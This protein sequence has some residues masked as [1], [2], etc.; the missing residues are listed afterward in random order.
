MHT[1]RFDDLTRALATNVSRR[2]VLKILGGSLVAGLLEPMH[3]WRRP[4]VAAADPVEFVESGQH[5]LFG[6]PA[7]PE[8]YAVVGVHAAKKRLL[9]RRFNLGTSDVFVDYS[10]QR[11]G[12]HACPDGTY[13]R[14][15]NDDHNLLIC[16][17]PVERGFTT[18]SGAEVLSPPNGH[19][20]APQRAGMHVCSNT[21]LNQVVVGIHAS[22]N[23]FL[24]RSLPAQQPPVPH[25]VRVPQSFNPTRAR[26]LLA[27]MAAGMS[28][29]DWQSLTRNW[30]THILNVPL[31]G[32]PGDPRCVNLSPALGTLNRRFA[33]PHPASDPTCSRSSS[34]TIQILALKPATWAPNCSFDTNLRFDRNGFLP[35]GVQQF[36]LAYRSPVLPGLVASAYLTLPPGYTPFGKYPA[37]LVTHGHQDHGKESTGRCPNDHDHANALALARSGAVTLAPDT[38]SFRNYSTLAYDY[39]PQNV[40]TPGCHSTHWDDDAHYQATCSVKNGTMMYRY[41]LD[42]IVRVSI[43][44]QIPGVDWNRIST[45]GLSLG[46]YQALWTA[47]LDPRVQRAAIAGI[48]E[49]M[50]KMETR[51]SD[52]GNHSCQEVPSISTDYLRDTNKTVISRQSLL[53][54]TEDIAAL[55]FS[56]GALLE[57]WGTADPD[58]VNRSDIPNLTERVVQVIGGKSLINQ[59]VFVNGDLSSPRNLPAGW[60]NNT[61]VDLLIE[62]L[63]HQFVNSVAVPFLLAT[64]PQIHRVV[65]TG[66][67]SAPTVTIYGDNFGSPPIGHPA[68]VTS[69]GIYG[70]NGSWYGNDFWIQDITH[71]WRAGYSDVSGGNCIGIVVRS[72]TPTQVVFTFGIACGSYDH[73]TIDPGDSVFI[74]LKT[75]SWNA[76]VA[77]SPA[78]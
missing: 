77:Y 16:A 71:D 32:A 15:Y 42:N 5:Q 12:M 18:F 54:G 40:L 31:P 22:K 29:E 67:S 26:G 53:I 28:M 76:S 41:L 47:A 49:P 17:Y 68:T 69:C 59:R 45:A 75:S 74:K 24:C 51:S 55:I 19:G 20:S 43:L 61:F 38:I 56:Q 48:F 10:T 58:F 4:E 78:E 27:M 72:W 66:N 39:D 30:L 25:P 36:Y 35:D 1:N 8:G 7:C 52:H 2:Q 44:R 37:V 14:A 46:G 73:W 33:G 23:V 50:D 3:L 13:A 63:D 62:G 70:N 64:E 21:D 11:S 65:F 60:T 34:R 9:C 57:T 6:M